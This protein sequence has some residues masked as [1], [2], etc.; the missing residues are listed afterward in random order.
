MEALARRRPGPVHGPH[1][2]AAERRVRQSRSPG[3]STSPTSGTATTSPHEP[4]LRLQRSVA[5]SGERYAGVAGQGGEQ[6]VLEV[7]V[8][9]CRVRLAAA[10]VVPVVTGAAGLWVIAG[11][12]PLLGEVPES[13]V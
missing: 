11:G 2:D 5:R 3:A 13:E 9:D 8:V 6:V 4:D 7:L 1:R 10:L 12:Q